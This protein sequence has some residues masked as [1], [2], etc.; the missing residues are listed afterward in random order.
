MLDLIDQVTAVAQLHIPGMHLH[1]LK[2]DRK[3]A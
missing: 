1:P 2:F 3:A